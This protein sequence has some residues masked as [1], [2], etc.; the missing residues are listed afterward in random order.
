MLDL[1]IDYISAG[2]RTVKPAK[3]GVQNVE[4]LFIM[5]ATILPHA[6][7]PQPNNLRR[8][9]KLSAFSF[10]IREVA[11]FPLFFKNCVYFGVNFTSKRLM[12]AGAALA[13][14]AAGAALAARAAGATAGGFGDIT[15][16]RETEGGHEAR[17]LFTTASRAGNSLGRSRQKELLELVVTFFTL[18]FENGH[19]ISPSGT[20][21]IIAIRAEPGKNR[22][23]RASVQIPQLSLPK[24]QGA[25]GYDGN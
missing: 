15:R 14:R 7:E 5:R 9:R 8:R 2:D 24:P 6:A 16:A 20:A 12:P 4:L 19:R 21:C 23:S 17:R 13:A 18:I 25:P 10:G 11:N 3:I 22:L 1:Q